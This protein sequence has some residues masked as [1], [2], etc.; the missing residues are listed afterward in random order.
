M[1]GRTDGREPDARPGDLHARHRL[2][3]TLHRHGADAERGARPDEAPGLR[4]PDDRETRYAYA[5]EWFDGARKPESSK[6]CSDRAGT[7][8]HLKRDKGDPAPPRGSV[9]DAPGAPHWHRGVQ[10]PLPRAT[11]SPPGSSGSP[12]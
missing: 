2:D 6:A 11:V 7:W 4:R 1:C 12:A 3:Q 10:R 5:K 9:I 8:F